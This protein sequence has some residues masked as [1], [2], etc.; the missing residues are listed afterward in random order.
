MNYGY[1]RY[2]DIKFKYK[3]YLIDILMNS[4]YWEE[5]WHP[6][7]SSSKIRL[8][9]LIYFIGT[10]TIWLVPVRADFDNNPVFLLR[11]S[12]VVIGLVSEPCF[13]QGR[14]MAPLLNWSFF[15]LFKFCCFPRPTAEFVSLKGN[16]PLVVLPVPSVSL[17]PY[18]VFAR[19]VWGLVHLWKL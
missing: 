10:E 14:T 15:I 2:I 6:E 8:V 19:L 4:V 17:R 13:H 9:I 18:W 1:E 7:D 16:I 11:F 3:S 12:K 5:L